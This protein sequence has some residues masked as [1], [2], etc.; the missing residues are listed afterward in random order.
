MPEISDST[1][2]LP[3]VTVGDLG[4]EHLEKIFFVKL[5]QRGYS[6]CPLL[7]LKTSLREMYAGDSE[8]ANRLFYLAHFVLLNL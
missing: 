5:G 7:S 6:L 8:Y 1:L 3:V 2:L 4:I